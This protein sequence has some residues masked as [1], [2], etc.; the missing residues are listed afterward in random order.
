MI[1]ESKQKDN[2]NLELDE[3]TQQ[4]E[5]ENYINEK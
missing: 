4:M 1:K 2:Y 3:D 5:E